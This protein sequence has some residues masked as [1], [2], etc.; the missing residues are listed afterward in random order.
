MKKIPFLL[1]LVLLLGLSPAPATPLSPGTPQIQVSS[2]A[3]ALIVKDVRI[4]PHDG[5]VHGTVF[6]RIGY[7]VPRLPHVHVYA[8]DSSG[9]VIADGCDKLSRHLLSE[10]RPVGNGH[11]TF[12]VDL[13]NLSARV[14]TLR[15]VADAEHDKDCKLAD[16]RLFK[17]L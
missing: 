16:H 10:P 11:S 3:P 13:G 17:L 5:N 2:D 7:T 15:V 12:S 14:A 8:L 4:D 6:L 1:S 9:K